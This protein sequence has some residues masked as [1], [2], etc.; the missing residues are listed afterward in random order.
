M[1]VFCDGAVQLEESGILVN[2]HYLFDLFVFMLLY[3]LDM[4]GST[5]LGA[6]VDQGW[7]WFAGLVSANKDRKLDVKVGF[8]LVG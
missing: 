7:V 5:P 6:D 8:K 2:I 1:A 4:W 3:T